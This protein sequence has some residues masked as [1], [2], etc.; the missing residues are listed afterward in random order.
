M[1]QDNSDGRTTSSLGK[2]IKIYFGAVDP[3][4]LVDTLGPAKVRQDW[5][6]VALVSVV[7]ALGGIVTLLLTSSVWGFGLISAGILIPVTR[8]FHQKSY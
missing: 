3:E 5:A 6:H 4:E 1:N 8:W 2:R 7:F